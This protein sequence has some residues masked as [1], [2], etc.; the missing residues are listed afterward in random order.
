MKTKLFSIVLIVALTTSI[1]SQNITNTLGAGGVFYIKDATS[2]FFTLTQSTGQVNI[3]KGLR[4]EVTGNSA[5][6]GVIFKGT[7]RF[8]HDY[9][10]PGTDGYN[11]FMGINAGNFTMSGTN[12]EASYNNAFGEL[13]LSSITTGYTN[14]AF[15]STALHSN[16][17][18]NGNSAFG[19]SSLFA[20]TGGQVN[21]AFGLSSLQANTTGHYNSAFGYASLYSNETGT[22][23]SALGSYSLM[24]ATG[25]FNTALGSKSGYNVT[26]GFNLT[27]IG[28]DAQPSAGTAMNEMTFGN[29]VTILRSG[30]STITTISDARDKKN[31]KDLNLGIDFLMKLKPRQFNWD[32]REWYGSKKS[33]G[34]KM[35]KAPT[36]GFIAQELDT[37]QMSENAEWLNLVLKTNPNKLEATSGN[38]LPII[39]KAI[40]DLKKENDVLKSK[41]EMSQVANENLKT[42]TDELKNRLTKY[43]KMQIQLAAEI[44]KLKANN[45]ETTNV[46]LGTK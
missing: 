36:A 1:Y 28:Y 31:I 26:T 10:A 5:T 9:K 15:G 44:E 19:M 3:L 45:N 40:Q 13:S 24:F 12:N 7:D 38:L 46:S 6:T 23:N 29:G 17:S 18:G 25:H 42:T 21:S 37:A 30:T 41:N 39:V 35:Q 8:I 14:S 27:L 2:N 11:I 22:Y 33:D 32:K 16:T 4:L 20:N 43:E 34:S